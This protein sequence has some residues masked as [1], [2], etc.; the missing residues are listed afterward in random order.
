MLMRS[1][2]MYAPG[3]SG[4][5]PS[6]LKD[7]STT[8]NE[9]AVP[10]PPIIAAHAGTPHRP[11]RHAS[12]QLLEV[13]FLA[14]GEERSAASSGSWSAMSWPPRVRATR[15]PP[16]MLTWQRNPSAFT[17]TDHPRRLVAGRPEV[18]SM[19]RGIASIAAKDA[20]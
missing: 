6:G 15:R 1:A 2:V 7:G 19:G 12:T 4:R 11:S 14:G 16:M 10:G 5:T 20:R 9:M 18:A 3:C 8:A 13:E 17:S